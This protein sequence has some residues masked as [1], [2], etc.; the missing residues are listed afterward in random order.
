MKVFG[1]RPIGSKLD[2]FLGGAESLLFFGMQELYRNQHLFAR[3]GIWE[4]HDRFQVG[5]HGYPASIEVDNLVDWPISAD[6]EAKRNLGTSQ[7]V[8]VQTPGHF[9]RGPQPQRVR[10]QRLRGRLPIRVIQGW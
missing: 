9:D 3:V 5:A 8:P 6:P 7:V 4:Q 10:W 2:R 1:I